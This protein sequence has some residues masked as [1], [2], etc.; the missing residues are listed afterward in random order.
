[1]AQEDGS[2]AILLPP[3]ANTQFR[4]LC[5]ECRKRNG[6]RDDGLRCFFHRWTVPADPNDVEEFELRD[7]DGVL[8]SLEKGPPSPK[9]KP[10]T[11]GNVFCLGCLSRSPGSKYVIFD[12]GTR[13]EV[14]A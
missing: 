3:R 2:M 10:Y 7:H 1:M 11:G 14:P 9:W 8:E 12:P 6:D 4:L 5:S 13:L